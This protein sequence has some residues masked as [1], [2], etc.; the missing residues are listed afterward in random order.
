MKA[1]DIGVTPELHERQARRNRIMNIVAWVGVVT[2]LVW[3]TA[4]FVLHKPILVA[5]NWTGSLLFGL[6]FLFPGARSRAWLLMTLGTA[7]IAGHHWLILGPD[8]ANHA[9]FVALVGLPFLIFDEDSARTATAWAI[10]EVILYAVGGLEI[11]F[12]EPLVRFPAEAQ[13]IATVANGVFAAVALLVVLAFFA[14]QSVTAE[15]A[16]EKELDRS[17]R[18]LLNVLPAPIAERLKAGESPLADHHPDATVLFA[19]IVGFTPLARSMPAAEVVEILSGLFSSFDAL[20]AEAGL[21]KIKTIGDAYM[22]AA[23]VPIARTDHAEAVADLALRMR[24]AARSIAD[25]TG[26]DLTVRIGIHSGDL[27]AGVIGQAKFAYDLWGDT[28]NTASR[29]ESHAV[30]DG[31]QIT[32]DT[33]SRLPERFVCERRGLVEVKGQGPI[34]TYWLVR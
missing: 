1:L 6:T 10:G 28:V 2:P 20:T 29:M 30:P 4:G 15:A 3:S 31:I 7:F 13:R 12:M 24:D 16:L 21:E 22:A 23:G 17:E 34:E 11:S 25:E 27:V 32:A 26:I 19:D 5:Y 14:R 8:V 33:R 9:W 18:L